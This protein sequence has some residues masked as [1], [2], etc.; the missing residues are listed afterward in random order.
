MLEQYVEEPNKIKDLKVE[1]I[2][3]KDRLR[4]YE[5][6]IK[7]VDLIVDNPIFTAMR[8]QLMIYK[9]KAYKKK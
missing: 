9:A 5:S 8:P 2:E 6:I 1:W 4:D 3:T 7:Q